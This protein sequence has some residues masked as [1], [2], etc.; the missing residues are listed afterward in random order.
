MAK[1]IILDRAAFFAALRKDNAGVFNR[2]LSQA[3]VEGMEALLDSAQRH[4]VVDIEHVA[5][6]LAEVYHETGSYMLGI[7]ETVMPSHTNKRPADATVK[8]RLEKAWKAGKMPWVQNPYWRDGAFGRGP[9]QLTHWDNYLRMGTALGVDLRNN[10]D[11]ALDAKIGADIAVVGL[12]EGLF[13][14]KKLSDFRF[15]DDLKADPKWNPRRMVNGQDGTDSK[16]AGYH[17]AFF[18]A[19]T[20]GGF[21]IEDEIKAGWFTRLA[22]KFMGAQYV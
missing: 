6:I 8:A 22:N 5:H 17:Q 18:K 19:L 20:A 13:T 1:R 14:G 4:Q 10:P 16:V 2:R 9:I 15:P 11:L 12:S 3:Q 7:K 21:R